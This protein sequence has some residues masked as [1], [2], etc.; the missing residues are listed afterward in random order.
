MYMYILLKKSSGKGRVK[1]CF[2]N[3]RAERDHRDCLLPVISF[4]RWGNWGIGVS[5]FCDGH[6]TVKTNLSQNKATPLPRQVEIL[7]MLVIY[8]SITV[9][10][11]SHFFY[12]VFTMFER[13][14]G[15]CVQN[16]SY[17]QYENASNILRVCR[18]C[19]FLVNSVKT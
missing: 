18:L 10:V 5:I 4:C 2:Q 7:P 6:M 19:N 11:N 1:V 14:T 12:L 13:V 9:L 8:F 17:F 3:F 15:I 16:S